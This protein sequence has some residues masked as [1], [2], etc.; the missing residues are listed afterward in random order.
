MYRCGGVIN[1]NGCSQLHDKAS[2][3][4]MRKAAEKYRHEDL[5]LYESVTN[6]GEDHSFVHFSFKTWV[7]LNGVQIQVIDLTLAV[8]R[9]VDPRS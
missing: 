6:S 9:L 5:S 8:Y 7:K 2:A 1:R 3:K 4:P